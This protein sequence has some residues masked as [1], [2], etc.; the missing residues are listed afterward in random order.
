MNTGN[1]PQIQEEILL[2][3]D[4]KPRKSGGDKGK[5]KLAPQIKK[6]V[7][8]AK[9]EH[10]LRN[11]FST[12]FRICLCMIRSEERYRQQTKYILWKLQLRRLKE[13]ELVR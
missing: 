11:F 7:T 6:D 9:S 3:A 12:I 1:A 10:T 5:G 8:V 2:A 4:V 13:P